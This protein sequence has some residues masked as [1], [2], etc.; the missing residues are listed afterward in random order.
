MSPRSM[1]CIGWAP[2]AKNPRTF[3][4][5]ALRRAKASFTA[6]SERSSPPTA[7]AMEPMKTNVAA[8]LNA[9]GS[10]SLP[11]NSGRQRSSQEVTGVFTCLVSTMM[12]IMSNTIADAGPA[13]RHP[14]LDEI[15]R[16][17]KV[18]GADLH[19]HAAV[20]RAQRERPGHHHD[21][22]WRVALLRLHLGDRRRRG[23][24]V[25]HH[26]SELRGLERL[27]DDLAQYLIRSAEVR[28]AHRRELRPRLPARAERRVRARRRAPAVRR[29]PTDS[30]A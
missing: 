10:I 13:G 14:A 28:C 26:A 15:R 7:R 29:E 24:D 27:A 6:A 17:R 20:Q 1:T 30:A 3:G 5:S 8:P 22:E 4:F 11:L 2:S 12:S 21:V 9:A 23:L 16:L 18:G 25:V 19:Q